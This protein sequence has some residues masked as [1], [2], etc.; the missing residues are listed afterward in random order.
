ML[1]K[2]YNACNSNIK[3]KLVIKDANHIEAAL[4]DEELYWG[5]V[6][7]FIENNIN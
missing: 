2:L 3:E 6:K 1:D 5:K 4:Q 7:N